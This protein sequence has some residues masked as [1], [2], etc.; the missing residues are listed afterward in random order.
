MK[1]IK[2]YF[3]CFVLC[4]VLF[5]G[6]YSEKRYNHIKEKEYPIIQFGADGSDD[7]D[8]T[9]AFIKFLKSTEEPCDLFIPPGIYK[10]KKLIIPEKIR[11]NFANGAVFDVEQSLKING[12]IQAGIQQIFS[13]NGK[14]NGN[15]KTNRVFP[16][17]FGAAGDGIQDDS[18]ALQ[19][20]ADLAWKSSGKLLFIPEGK[21]LFEKDI[22]FRCNIDSNGIFLKKIEIDDSKTVFSYASF[23]HRHY[24]KRSKMLIFKTDTKAV[25]LSPKAFWG[26]K[27]NDF[28]IPKFKGIS[29]VDG[30][31][32]INLEE[33]ATINFFS[34]DFFTAR[35]HKHGDQ[36]Y[37]KRD[38]CQLVSPRGDVFPEFMFSFLAPPKAEKWSKYK[39]YKKG[40]YCSWQGN[41][42]K[43]VLPS[44]PAS[45]Y[46][47]K[48][49]YKGTVEIGPVCPRKSMETFFKFKY[50]NGGNDKIRIWNKLKTI[51]SY[52]PP[53]KPLT[54]NGLIVE[55][56]LKNSDGK[57]KRIFGSET[58]K[59]E[60]SNMIFNNLRISCKSREA[61]LPV[62][63]RTLECL[64][65]TYNNCYFSGASNHGLGYNI[66]NARCAAVTYNNCISANCRDGMGGKFG[67][68]ITVKGGFYNRID[69]HYGKNYLIKDVVINAVSTFIPG[70][71]T[72]QANQ[73]KWGFK[74]HYA[75]AFSGGN[76]RIENCRIYNC[77][78]VFS[79][80]TD[81]ADMFGSVILK[82]IDIISDRPV[83][84]FLHSISKDYFDYTGKLRVPSQLLIENIHMEKDFPLRIMIRNLEAYPYGR[85]SVRNCQYLQKVMLMN[86]GQANFTECSFKNTVFTCS[87]KELLFFRNCIF[88]GTT[89]GLE[90]KNIGISTG[91]I[92][93]NGTLK[94]ILTE[95][96]NA[97]NS[98]TNQSSKKE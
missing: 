92:D 39:K 27:E 55:I 15:I 59:V 73:D 95:Q 49:R 10:I 76:I 21:Y 1:M 11:L 38:I 52:T 5:T 56:Y 81:T 88:S 54:V 37:Y 4:S 14:I 43:A 24:A 45:V 30:K 98:E 74:P 35:Q 34:S 13:G 72:P 75:F 41:I 58:V 79:V 22:I 46:K 97:Q 50:P 84:L 66:A 93:K 96:T 26:I 80:R 44:G 23:C 83:T 17:W 53:Q 2:L 64:N 63:L 68:N 87:P 12:P 28:K 7:K 65:V 40:K 8:D 60:R 91:N 51:V 32:K 33:G 89:K 9:E 86:S 82:D 19:N 47:N 70:Y 18:T 67:K 90:K 25:N 29:T 42:Y 77:E 94:C 6:C 61:T 69:D 3:F 48:N 57:S 16:Q 62:L 31:S 71:G 78:G 20:A 85:I 36:V